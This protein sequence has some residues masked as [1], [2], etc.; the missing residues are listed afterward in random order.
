[1]LHQVSWISSILLHVPLLSSGLY[2]YISTTTPPKGN[3]R[4]V[5]EWW[6][7]LEYVGANKYD[8]RKGRRVIPL[9]SLDFSD[10]LSQQVYISTDNLFFHPRAMCDANKYIINSNGVVIEGNE[11]ITYSSDSYTT[12]LLSKNECR[13]RYLKLALPLIIMSKELLSLAM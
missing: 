2:M 6:D 12:S 7:C 5:F 9:R 10:L 1:M 3:W 4:M 11:H 13:K 8:R